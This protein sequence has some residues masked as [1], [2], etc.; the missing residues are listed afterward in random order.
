MNIKDFLIGYEA[1]KAKNSGGKEMLYTDDVFQDADGTSIKNGVVTI[2]HGLGVV[3]DIILVVYADISPDSSYLVSATGY[4]DAM[5]EAIGG[6]YK[7]RVN[8]AVAQGGVMGVGSNVGIE[9]DAID[10]M[11]GMCIRNATKTTFTI[12]NGTA[13]ILAD[14]RY[15]YVCIGKVL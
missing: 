15:Q 10:E 13:P 11:R 12:G 8:I 5:L 14:K 6:G 4:S 3:P 2:E 9:H 7:C 1:G